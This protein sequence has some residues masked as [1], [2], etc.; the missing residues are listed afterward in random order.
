MMMMMMMM[1]IVIVE[2]AAV[3]NTIQI[4]SSLP[5]TSSRLS[6][7]LA[8]S[9]HNYLRLH[10]D[11]DCHHECY[12]HH[13]HHRSHT[14]WGLMGSGYL[15]GTFLTEPQDQLSQDLSKFLRS[16][17]FQGLQLEM[18]G[19][20]WST[21]CPFNSQAG[22]I[23]HSANS[24]CAVKLRQPWP[25]PL[26]S[27]TVLKGVLPPLDQGIKVVEIIWPFDVV[28]YIKISQAVSRISLVEGRQDYAPFD[29]AWLI[30]QN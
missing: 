7:I 9:N 20:D 17:I 29:A 22:K 10:H 23:D 4:G 14:S 1:T 16:Y 30:F 18:K 13:H 26:A 5:S 12:V 27:S 6:C 28:W 8:P 2:L 25:R 11:D 19:H 15:F 24:E 3:G 21:I